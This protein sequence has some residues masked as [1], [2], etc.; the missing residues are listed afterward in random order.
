MS[1]KIEY[2]QKVTPMSG[3]EAMERYGGEYPLDARILVTERFEPTALGE[4]PHV[5]HPASK[6]ALSLRSRSV[7]LGN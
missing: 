6:T 4:V 1:E 7:E 5:Y 2:I 3:R